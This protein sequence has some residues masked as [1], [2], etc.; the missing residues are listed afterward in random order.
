MKSLILKGSLL[1]TLCSFST[2]TLHKEVPSLAKRD[3]KERQ[4]LIEALTHEVRGQP[5]LGQKAVLDVIN[6]RKNTKGFPDT[7]C[8]VVHQKYAF[9]YRIELKPG[10][11][12]VHNFT[13]DID[14]SAV[15]KIE[16]LVDFFLQGDYSPV[17]STEVLWYTRKEV[18][19][20]WMKNMKIE[21]VVLDHKFLKLK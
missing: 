18:T 11:I 9:S 13:K 16:N 2:T 3:S 5:L 17:L 4:C 20:V 12:K 8:G 10:A 14:K 7:F 1:I 6:N 15:K 21:V 19:K